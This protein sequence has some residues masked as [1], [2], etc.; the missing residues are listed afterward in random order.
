MCEIAV[1]SGTSS[2]RGSRDISITKTYERKG[3]IMLLKGKKHRKDNEVYKERLQMPLNTFSDE[4]KVRLREECKN[5]PHIFSEEFEQKMAELMQVKPKPFYK[6]PALQYAASIVLV[7][8]SLTVFSGEIDQINANIP[9]IDIRKWTDS[10]IW[11]GKDVTEEDKIDNDKPI[12]ADYFLSVDVPEGFELTEQYITDAAVQAVYT[13]GDRFLKLF[14]AKGAYAT[15][16][17]NQN[18]IIELCATKDGIEYMVIKY[19]DEDIINVFW[20][21]RNGYYYKVLG[22]INAD[23]IR[24][25]VEKMTNKK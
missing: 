13:S 14:V 21:G 19:Q 3:V 16:I 18:A 5:A 2:I 10:D 17:D 1:L 24:C 25:L 7:L 6:R 15:Q 11:L 4:E 12:D 22:K 20:N 9:S 8:M 23:E